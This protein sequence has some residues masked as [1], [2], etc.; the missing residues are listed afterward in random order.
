MKKWLSMTTVLTL[1]L[2]LNACCLFPW[3]HP[4]HQGGG[5]G[6]GAP[7]QQQGHGKM[8]PRR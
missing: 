5:M 1:T 7:M 6:G 2:F 8:Q 3:G 4:P